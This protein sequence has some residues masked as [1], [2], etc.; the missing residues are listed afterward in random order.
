ML[1]NR[2][3]CRVSV[4]IIYIKKIVLSKNFFTNRNARSQQ[5]RILAGASKPVEV[6]WTGGSEQH[7][8]HQ[9]LLS[10]FKGRRHQR[11]RQPHVRQQPLPADVRPK[12]ILRSTLRLSLD[13]DEGS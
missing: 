12:M 10:R 4:L 8:S 7:Q 11:P 13:Y 6:V 2:E 9:P 5:E 1:L 3:T